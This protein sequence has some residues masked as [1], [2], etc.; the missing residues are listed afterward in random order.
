MVTNRSTTNILLFRRKGSTY[1][2]PTMEPDPGL[3]ALPGDE[4]LREGCGLLLADLC[5]TL[6]QML[7]CQ[8]E[9]LLRLPDSRERKWLEAQAAV[10]HSHLTRIQNNL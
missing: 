6:D 7:Q 9:Q 1:D 5:K 8:V 10:A 4:T 3:P 2:G